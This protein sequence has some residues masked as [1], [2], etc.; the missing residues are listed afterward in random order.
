MGRSDRHIRPSN[1]SGL[2]VATRRPGPRNVLPCRCYFAIRGRGTLGHSS[3][4]SRKPTIPVGPRPAGPAGSFWEWLDSQSPGPSIAAARRSGRSFRVSFI[5]VSSRCCGWT[6]PGASVQDAAR[7]R[8]V[9]QSR[10]VGIRSASF[11]I[12]RRCALMS[13]SRWRL[14]GSPERSH[15]A[16]DA[17]P[18]MGALWRRSLLAP[19]IGWSRGVIQD[20]GRVTAQR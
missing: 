10:R 5:N 11:G 16:S 2:V 7:G 8:C 15:L 13:R 19:P 6:G 3:W 14:E 4:L 9:L 20:L 17:A 1:D 18:R 12:A